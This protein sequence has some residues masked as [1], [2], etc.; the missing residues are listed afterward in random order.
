MWYFPVMSLW[1]CISQ[2]LQQR[3]MLWSNDSRN[4]SKSL[5]SAWLSNF[6]Q[7]LSKFHLCHTV[8]E[9]LTRAAADVCILKQLPWNNFLML[10]LIYCLFIY[11]SC[12]H[13]H[14]CCCLCDKINKNTGKSHETDRES[15]RYKAVKFKDCHKTLTVNKLKRCIQ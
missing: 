4:V 6:V 11:S 5:D 9:R 8:P 2:S 7:S 10:H 14:I 13:L 12:S 1:G 3:L 15:G